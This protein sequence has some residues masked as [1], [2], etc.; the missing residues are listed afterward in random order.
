VGTRRIVRIHRHRLVHVPPQ[1]LAQV[2]GAGSHD[3]YGS[4]DIF[5]RHGRYADVCAAVL[6]FHAGMLSLNPCVS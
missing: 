4:H 3:R 2:F 6:D 5:P 1:E